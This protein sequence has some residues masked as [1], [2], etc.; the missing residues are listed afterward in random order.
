MPDQT[1]HAPKSTLAH[2]DVVQQ[3]DTA[4]AHLRE[5]RLE[6]V[7]D[8]VARM[9]PVQ[10][11]QVDAAVGEMTHGVIERRSDQRGERAVALVVIGLPVGVDRLVIKASLGI[12]GPR[13]NGIPG[14]VKTEML[15]GLGECRVAVTRMSAQLDE[16][17]RA[18]DVD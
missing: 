17:P 5:P 9:K 18:Q 15:D 3:H 13:V 4:G 6:V 11:Q 1:S 2:V 10:V 16:D 14:R 7:A 8:G 12:A